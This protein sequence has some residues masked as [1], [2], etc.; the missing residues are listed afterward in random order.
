MSA[1]VIV[2]AGPLGAAVA[3]Q[4]MS[5]GIARR[6]VLVDDAGD[7]ARG[8]AL[9]IRQA[10]PMAGS[11]SAVDGGSDIGAV[12]GAP[13]VVIADR[14]GSDGEWRGDAG[15]ERITRVRELNPNALIVCAGPAQGALVEAYVSERDGDRAR[16][17]GSAP[18]AFRGALVALVCLETGAA[19]GD[20]SLATIGRPPRDLFVPWDGAAI[21]GSR[22]TE[23]LPAAVLARLDRQA[24]LL[25]PP[26]PLTLAGGAVRVVRMVLRETGGWV[27]VTLVPPSTA[28]V[29]PGAVALPAVAVGGTMRMEWPS[30][31]PRDRVRLESVLAV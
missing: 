15:L 12:V 2:G 24:P 10:A 3:H 26:G 27:C 7:V 25:W 8:L 17:I 18:E 5:A 16:I 22:A 28:D 31:A 23:V 9:D 14:Y 21:G 19:P 1:L 29:Q 6:I 20:V 11:S 13:V 30:L 4:A